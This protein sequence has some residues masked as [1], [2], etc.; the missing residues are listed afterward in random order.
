MIAAPCLGLYMQAH[1]RR[2]TQPSLGTIRKTCWKL[3]SLRLMDRDRVGKL[4][5]LIG[6]QPTLLGIFETPVWNALELN[7]DLLYRSFLT[8]SIL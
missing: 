1:A 4:K 8:S 6:T 7:I 5:I 2:T 3:A